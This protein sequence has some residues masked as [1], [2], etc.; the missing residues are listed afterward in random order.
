MRGACSGPR[1]RPRQRSRRDGMLAL[2]TPPRTPVACI[3]G[4]VSAAKAG[5]GV[6][7]LPITLGDAEPDLARVLPPTST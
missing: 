3:C 1:W 5:V 4:S 2:R 7:A 6:A